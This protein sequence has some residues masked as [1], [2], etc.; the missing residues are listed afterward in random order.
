MDLNLV[1]LGLALILST[2]YCCTIDAYSEVCETHTTAP[3]NK[4]F[5]ELQIKLKQILHLQTAELL[6]FL[7][8]SQLGNKR[9]IIAECLYVYCLWCWNEAN[10]YQWICCWSMYYELYVAIPSE[11][12]IYYTSEGYMALCASNNFEAHWFI[13]VKITFLTSAIIL[14]NLCIYFICLQVKGPLGLWLFASIVHHY[15]QCFQFGVL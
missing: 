13:I 2:V 1:F 5:N 7:S 10:F 11:L 9:S 3:I 4:R 12:V 15:I 14:I 6:S 8:L